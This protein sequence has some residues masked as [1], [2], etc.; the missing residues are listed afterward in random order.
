MNDTQTPK[1]ELFIRPQA[2]F[3]LAERFWMEY[4]TVWKM[5]LL[6][7]LIDKLLFLVAFGF[8]MG[9]IIRQMGE[10]SY[11]AFLVPGMA[12]SASAMVM[13]MAM[14]YGA[15][16]RFTGYQVWQSWLAT[17]IR[18]QEILFAEL[19][20]ASCRVMPSVVVLLIIAY[21]MDALPSISGALLSLPIIFLTSFV[22]GSITLCFTS[23]IKRVLYFGYL[24]TLWVTPMYLLSGTFFDLS[25]APSWMNWLSHVYPLRHILD[26]V[27]PLMLGQSVDIMSALISCAVLFGLFV[28]SF[29]YALRQFKKRLFV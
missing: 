16:E 25:H 13:S 22:Y 19:F 10:V 20:Y 26:V 5:L 27:R 24:M 17:P 15:F 12:C 4:R 14:G 3:A 6:R 21:A 28:V 1:K 11:L 7:D 9:A 23:N 8:G 2:V 18:L 29:A